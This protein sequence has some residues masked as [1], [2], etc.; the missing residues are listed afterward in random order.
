MVFSPYLLLSFSKL[1]LLLVFGQ[2][3]AG[4]I[5]VKDTRV[6]FMFHMNIEDTIQFVCLLILRLNTFSD[7]EESSN[8]FVLYPL[9]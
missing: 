5:E 3:E 4:K 2:V 7:M 9:I 8:P 6:I 1:S